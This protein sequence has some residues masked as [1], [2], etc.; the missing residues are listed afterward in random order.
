MNVSSKKI[1]SL[2]KFF[3]GIQSLFILIRFELHQLV[4]SLINSAVTYIP[5]P[6]DRIKRI[7]F[8]LDLRWNID[9]RSVRRDGGP[10]PLPERLLPPGKRGHENWNGLNGEMPRFRPLVC[11]GVKLYTS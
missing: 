8:V 1:D 11:T 10:L 5:L 9:Q 2:S 3:I 7:F 6:E 4:F